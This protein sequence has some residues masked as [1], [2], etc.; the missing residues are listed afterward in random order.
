MGR[1]L[2]LVGIATV[3]LIALWIAYKILKFLLPFILVAL[4]IVVVYY[5]YKWVK[6]RH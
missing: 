6:N 3:F 1:F 2:A 5:I 4:A